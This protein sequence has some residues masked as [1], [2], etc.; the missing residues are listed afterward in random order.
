M[1]R[2]VPPVA[3][4]LVLAHVSLGCGGYRPVR[5][6][7]SDL[8]A[9]SRSVRP[10]IQLPGSGA[11]SAQG[12]IQQDHVDVAVEF[13]DERQTKEAFHADFVRSGIQPVRLLIQNGSDQPYRFRKADVDPRSI[14]AASV[15]RR[16]YVHPAETVARL[17]KWVAFFIPGLVFESIVEPAT[18]LDFPGIEEAARRPPT[19]DNRS[20]KA[21]FLKHEIADAEIGPNGSLAGVLFIRPPRLGSV[22]TVKLFTARTQQP[23][24]FEVPTPPPVYVQARPYPHP[25]EKVW[26]AVLATSN[27]IRSWRLVER[28][29]PRGR[30]TVR[31][32]V[33]LLMWTNAVQ[34]T[35][36]VEQLNERRTQVRLELP[37][38][39]STTAA[40]GTR[41]P[42]IE[43]F[44]QGLDH[45]LPAA[46]VEVGAV[47]NPPPPNR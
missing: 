20:I 39:R 43:K 13:L 33:K 1:R 18:S 12:R 44:F 7:R 30:I 24:V 21:D 41:R 11:A 23:A 5:W 9:P 37:L 42:S 16:V 29:K 34:M 4:G 45:L 2:R 6:P 14:P 40:Y 15:A 10:P 27:D 31:K 17:V 46:P 47:D 36:A 32:G 25:Y 19:P 38:P 28:D 35:V 8:W 26:D 22:L 3:L